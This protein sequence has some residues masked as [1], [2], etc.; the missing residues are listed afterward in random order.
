VTTLVL[1]TITLLAAVVL[2]GVDRFRH[3]KGPQPVST[4]PV[5]AE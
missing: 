3:D 5:V 4:T 1:A 2:V